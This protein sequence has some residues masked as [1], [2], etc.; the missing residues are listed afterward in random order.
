M[1]KH[2]KRIRRPYRI[3][4]KKS[5]FQNSFFKSSTLILLISGILFYS[6]CFLG[7]FQV[8]EIRISGTEKVRKENLENTI[9]VLVEKNIL[10]FSTKSIFL[11]N[12]NQTKERVLEIFP[13]ISSIYFKKNLPNSLILEI[14]E[15][16]P[17][18]V[19][20][21]DDQSF[22]I[23]KQGVIFEDVSGRE[24]KSL[25][26]RNPSISKAVL[27]DEVIPEPKISQILNTKSAL[28]RD[29]GIK[30]QEVEIASQEKLDFITLE[31]WAIYFNLEKDIN[32]QIIKLREVLE[33]EIP[34]EN[35]KNLEYI[36]LRFGN[37]APY[38]Y[39]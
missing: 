30:I 5:I 20:V 7:L 32:W 18:A 8:K 4:R 13:S 12:A 26:L 25:R 36:E 1:K 16:K 15:R 28:D 11:V 27:G 39:R 6:I 37:L 35:R 23:D 2:R 14:E 17:I 31:G 10:S 21:Q 33:Q 22:F 19:F 9:Q 24:S 3:R 34:S 38:K 29:L